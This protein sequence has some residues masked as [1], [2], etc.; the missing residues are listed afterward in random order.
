MI[1]ER[2]IKEKTKNA[3][4]QYV[5]QSKL[6]SKKEYRWWLEMKEEYT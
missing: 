4:S 6:R 5:L 1:Q 3:R 2:E